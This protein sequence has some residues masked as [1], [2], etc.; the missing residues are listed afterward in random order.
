MTSDTKE[1]VSVRTSS[2]S[3]VHQ[4]LSDIDLPTRFIESRRDRKI[5]DS[6]NL[7]PLSHHEIIVEFHEGASANPPNWNLK[8]KL[9]N[10]VVALFIV[11]NS[12][13]S[14]ALP[15]NAIPE[16]M[17][18][19]EKTGDELKVL[20][21]AVYLLGYVVGSMIFSTL[22]ETMGRKPILVGS[23]T[24]FVLSTLGC[25]FAPNWWCFLILRAI[26]GIAGAAPQTV[27]G[28]LYADLFSDARTRGR[29]MVTY[30]SASSFGPILGAIISGCSVKYG[31]RWV[32]RISFIVAGVTWV[33]LLF[34]S[35]T[36]VP[37]LLK[38]QASKMRKEEGC[39][40]YFSRN[41][42]E[43]GSAF[44][45]TQTITR[46][47]AMLVY[48]P[49]I[50]S[51]TVYIAIAYS[52]VFFYFQAY[53]IIF[54]G[55]FNLDIETTSLTYIP[56]GIGASLSGLVTLAYDIFYER[57]K[58]RGKNWTS[59]PELHRLPLSCFSGPC[60]TLSIFWL[61]WTAKSSIHWA[62]PMASGLVFGFGNQIIFTS[63]LTYV[64]DAYKIYSASALAASVAIRSIVGALLPFAANPLYKSLGVSWA[65]S[66]LG[67]LSF[68]CI[69]IPFLLLYFGPLIR[70]RSPL[71]QR[72]VAQ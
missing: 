54:E 36:F 53:P 9:Y 18:D 4:V 37:V 33:A 35:E 43:S 46:P 65:T 69:P 62:V 11:I 42:L 59:S 29:A 14:T 39:N 41:E 2:P 30:M 1:C 68:A 47:I 8:K 22:S 34:T 49:I 19:L 26:C 7:V 12:G 6:Y 70:E 71:C 25:A 3:L 10:A 38:R 64:A 66:I 32:F 20:P 55:T 67:F 28:G 23:F 13:I 50:L 44:T 16:I 72:L 17:Q 45:R 57:N 15:S 5:T 52:L 21:T 58:K 48:E 61:A 40:L 60:L 27:V 31:W 63:L 56:I 24:L 51:T